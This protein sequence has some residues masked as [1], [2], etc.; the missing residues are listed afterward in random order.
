VPASEGRAH[1]A[2][3]LREE[4]GRCGLIDHEDLFF[5]G[6]GAPLR[7][8]HYPTYRWRTSLTKLQLRYRKAYPTRHSVATMWRVYS[9]WMD[10][11][12]DA[13]IEAIKA[14]MQAPSARKRPHRRSN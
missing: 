2:P 5:Q 4:F 7:T 8:L 10:G 9:A 12:T 3:L 14:A 13:D 6:N 11:A 1:S